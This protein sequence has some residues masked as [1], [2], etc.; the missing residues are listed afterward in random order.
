[1]PLDPA[2]GAPPA[3][4]LDRADGAVP[5]VPV[6]P[7]GGAVP[8]VPLDRT[9]NLLGA[10]SLVIADRTADAMAEAGG[11]PDRRPRR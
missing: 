7:G 2:G 4:P 9:A 1:V 6:P 5:G 3:V 10:L 11:R 8:G